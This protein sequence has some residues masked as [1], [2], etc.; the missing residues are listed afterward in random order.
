MLIM[1]LL[2]IPLNLIDTLNENVIMLH[3]PRK[4][5]K[6]GK[7]NKMLCFC[8]IL[9]VALVFIF[10]IIYYKHVNNDNKLL[11]GIPIK[12]NGLPINGLKSLFNIFF[13][14]IK[15]TAPCNIKPCKPDHNIQNIRN[16]NR[17]H[18]HK[19]INNSISINRI[20]IINYLYI[21]ILSKYFI[22]II[23]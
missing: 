10:V 18:S 23:K 8:P 6:L 19:L 21:I 22:I 3:I 20:S 2:I 12:L 1:L 4:L 17:D 7:K 13:F 5:M 11:Q 9:C 15:I 16:T 14:S